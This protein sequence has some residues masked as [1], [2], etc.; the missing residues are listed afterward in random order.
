V[1]VWAKFKIVYEPGWLSTESCVGNNDK[2]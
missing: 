2:A 1:I